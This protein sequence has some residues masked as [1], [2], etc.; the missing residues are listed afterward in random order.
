MPDKLKKRL[1]VTEDD[2]AY[3]IQPLVTRSSFFNNP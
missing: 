2:T 1:R 3:A